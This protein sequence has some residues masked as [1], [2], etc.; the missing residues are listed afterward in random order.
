M[1]A[2]GDEAGAESLLYPPRFADGGVTQADFL[3]ATSKAE[4]ADIFRSAG[5]VL[6]D[7]AVD[8]TYEKAKVLDPNGLVSVQSFRMALNGEA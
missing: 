7:A 3:T 4:I 6:D 2:A 1:A 5:F 8:A